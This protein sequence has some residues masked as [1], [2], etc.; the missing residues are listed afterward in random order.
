MVAITSF[1]AGTGLGSGFH[2]GDLPM[3]KVPEMVKP[4]LNTFFHLSYVWVLVFIVAGIVRCVIQRMKE[5]S[6]A[7]RVRRY[8]LEEGNSGIQMQDIN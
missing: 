5:K 3:T 1:A 8:D 6:R 4:L 7:R 2:L